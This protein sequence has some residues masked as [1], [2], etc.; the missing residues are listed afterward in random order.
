[1]FR[2]AL[3]YCGGETL[4]WKTQIVQSD[5]ATPKSCTVDHLATWQRHTLLLGK[6]SPIGHTSGYSLRTVCFIHMLWTCPLSASI[7]LCPAISSLSLSC[8]LCTAVS[9]VPQYPLPLIL[10]MS[11][12]T[13]LLYSLPNYILGPLVSSVSFVQLYLSSVPQYPLYMMTLRETKS[14]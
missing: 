7:L 8:I 13:Y 9:S 4:L 2:L 1:M 6:A 11:R 5:E 10:H 12:S 3:V 14:V